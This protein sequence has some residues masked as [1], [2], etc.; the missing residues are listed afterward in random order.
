M[1]APPSLTSAIEVPRVSTRWG[2]TTAS[3]YLDTKEME[4]IAHVRTFMHTNKQTN[5]HS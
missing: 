4:R 1:N 3:V 2:V 5:K